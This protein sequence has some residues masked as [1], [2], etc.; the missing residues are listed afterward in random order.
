MQAF[1]M[2]GTESRENGKLPG[3]DEMSNK[4]SVVSSADG[5]ELEPSGKRVIWEDLSDPK[6]TITVNANLAETREMVTK[7]INESEEMKNT[8]DGMRAIRRH[9][10]AVLMI[11]GVQRKDFKKIR[12]LL[13]AEE[14]FVPD[15]THL[16]RCGFLTEH[17]Y[18]QDDWKSPNGR[19]SEEKTWFL[20]IIVPHSQASEE[21][22]DYS[23]DLE[24]A[25][26][27][28]KK[29][30]G[31][32]AFMGGSMGAHTGFFNFHM[33]RR[34]VDD[35]EEP[36]PLYPAGVIMFDVGIIVGA[37]KTATIANEIQR[38]LSKIL[39][40]PRNPVK[41]VGSAS[42]WCG[43]GHRH[44]P[45]KYARGYSRKRPGST[46]NP[47][48]GSEMG[49]LKAS[50]RRWDELRQL[51]EILVVYDRDLTIANMTAIEEMMDIV[52]AAHGRLRDDEKNGSNS[53][54][55]LMAPQ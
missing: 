49:I 37:H 14:I 27:K 33:A 48:S 41:S 10:G 21:A 52:L 38:K 2:K 35:R 3:E 45:A 39:E 17:H 30:P 1:I 9:G 15:M 46:P 24:E 55:L 31:A 44:V 36:N 18:H 22:K 53:H 6:S 12:L 50:V 29:I 43:G 51:L 8:G 16:K 25:W 54:H 4:T 19:N 47:K 32:E 13:A 11:Y 42:G 40:S 23:G 28:I 20:K 7:Y 26:K 34:S 5:P